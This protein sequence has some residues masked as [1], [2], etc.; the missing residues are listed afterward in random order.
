M[1]R[2]S[3]TKVGAILCALKGISSQVITDKT[4]IDLPKQSN[5]AMEILMSIIRAGIGIVGYVHYTN[6][7][8]FPY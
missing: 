4:A 6:F 2:V 1:F 7:I 3:F 5:F 8:I